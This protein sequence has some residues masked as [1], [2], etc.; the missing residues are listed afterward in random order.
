MRL[1]DLSHPIAPG[2]PSFP[3]TPAPTFREPFTVVEHGFRERE[4][5]L[6]SHTGTHADAPAHI[7]PD[8]VTFD[9]YG[10]ER[11]AGTAVVVDAPAGGADADAAG[12]ANAAGAAGAAASPVMVTA[13]HLAAQEDRL[14]GAEFVLLRT[15][16]SARWGREDY[17]RD[18]PCLTAEA[19]RWLIARGVRGFGVDTCS[20]DP[21]DSTE[22]PVHH[23]LLG[24]QVLIVENLTNLGAVPQGS[25]PFLALPLPL[26]DADGGPVRAVAMV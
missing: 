19:A 3:G 17:F 14:Q 15:G 25:F 12:A 26:R 16:W 7:L 2:M 18:F 11:F 6:I 13:D 8:G 4:I 23:A 10:I 21:A 1:I 9:A 24:A 5:T 22:L 20:V